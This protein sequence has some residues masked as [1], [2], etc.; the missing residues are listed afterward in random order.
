M[1]VTYNMWSRIEDNVNMRAESCFLE[2]E[3]KYT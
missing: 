2:I 1:V 3:Q